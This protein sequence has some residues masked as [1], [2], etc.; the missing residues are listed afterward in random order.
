MM[1]HAFSFFFGLLSAP[2]SLKP[3]L[4]PVSAINRITAKLGLH[5][6]KHV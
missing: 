4:P 3:E 1:R 6:S 5:V 2:H